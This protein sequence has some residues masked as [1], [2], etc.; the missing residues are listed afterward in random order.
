ML[1]QFVSNN[2]FFVS[3]IVIIYKTKKLFNSFHK[4]LFSKFNQTFRALNFFALKSFKFKG[5]F[6]YSS[7]IQVSI[8]LN[9][10]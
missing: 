6:L 8:Y 9:F 10:F 3:I 4:H 2:N 7:V 1:T 5:S